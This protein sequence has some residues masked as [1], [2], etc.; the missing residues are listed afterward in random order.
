M[1]IDGNMAVLLTGASS[2]IG[3]E[4][5]LSFARRKAR[6]FLVARRAE[7]LS[8]VAREAERL[9]SPRVEIRVADLSIPGMGSRI[10]TECEGALGGVDVLV[11]NAGYGNSSP[12]RDYSPEQMARMWQ[13]NYQTGYES[14]HAVLPGM[15]AR[16]KGHIFI[17]ASVVGHRAIP[18]A[19]AYCAT[20]SAQ[21]ALGEA[22]FFELAGT[23]VLAT[24]ICPGTTDT[25]FFDEVE[26]APSGLAPRDVGKM[27]SPHVVADAIVDLV[28]RKR[29]EV[30]FT[31]SARAALLANRAAPWLVDLGIGLHLK[32]RLARKAGR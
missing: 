28:G 16:K 26:R 15:I 30:T 2:G 11:A 24:T 23:G 31:L 12:V 9:G 20:K 7:R 27:Q 10:A 18:Y 17:V 14:I 3:R 13:V 8:E 4:T 25:A 29:R 6:L 19:A 5:A 22:L 21:I 32:R 1:T